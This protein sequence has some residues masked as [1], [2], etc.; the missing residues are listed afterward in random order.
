MT[1]RYSDD[2]RCVCLHPLVVHRGVSH[3]GACA[4][5]RWDDDY[6]DHCRCAA[7]RAA[8]SGALADGNG[9]VAGALVRTGEPTRTETHLEP[10]PGSGPSLGTTPK[11]DDPAAAAS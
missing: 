5:M 2:P 10:P 11:R 9:P 8:L 6:A 3:G 7:F 4:A 1:G